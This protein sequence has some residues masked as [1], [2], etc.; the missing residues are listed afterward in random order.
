MCDHS[1]NPK[2]VKQDIHNQEHKYWSRRSFLQALG[3]VG[4]GSILLGSKSISAS[5]PSPLAAALAASESDRILVLIRLKGG[6]DGLNTIVPIYDYDRYANLRPTLKINPSDVYNLSPDFGLPNFMSDLQSMWGN[7]AMKVV[8]GVGYDD[9]SLSHFSGSDIWASTDANDEARTG[10]WGRHFEELYPDYLVS[11]PEIPPA[12]Q[13]GSIGNLI[14]DGSINNYA[15]SV[16]NPNQLEAIAQNGTV[17]DMNNLPNCTYGS[18]LQ[19]MRGTTNTTYN[20]AGVIHQAYS[21]SSNSVDYIDDQL[22]Q[23]L[24]IVARMIKGNLGTKVYMVTL[25]GFDTHANQKDDHEYLLNNLS[26]SV[27]LFFDDLATVGQDENVLAMTFSEFGR[28]PDENGSLGTDHGAA[29]PI[30]LFGPALEDNGFVGTHPSLTNFDANNN[31]AH[32]IDFRQIYAS[33]MQ[34]WLCIDAN[35]VNQALLGQNFERIHLGFNCE[36]LSTGDLNVQSTF[37]HTPLYDQ[38]QVSIRITNQN[39]QHTVVKLFNI[40]GQEVASLKNEILFSG[41]HTINIK[42]AAR[43]RLYPGQYIYRISVGNQHYSRSIILQ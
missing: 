30:M 15:F 26:N 8:H 12:I 13:I 17:H 39:T 25:S 35:T 33:V 7:G 18:Q 20:Y 19:F 14:F 38:D 36:S 43:K 37:S 32:S 27:K 3:L 6:N 28:R 41:T 11:P 31:L 34:E 42:Q 4:G 24:A 22:G 21:N 9:S 1:P 10:W 40:I 29:A 23:Q 5:V 2:K 16:A